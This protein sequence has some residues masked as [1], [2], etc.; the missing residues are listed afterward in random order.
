MKFQSFLF[1]LQ[2]VGL[3]TI[4]TSQAQQKL[5]Q[6][7]KN[8]V[9]DIV[10][11]MTLEEKARLVIG[12]GM[13]FGSGGPIIGEADGR[14]P[15]AAGNSINIDRFGI[16]GA[17][18]ADGPAGIRIEPYRNRDST[19][20]F[21]ATAWPVGTLL[22]SSWDTVLIRR[23]GAAF[24]NEVK[25][26]GTDVILAPGMNIQRDPLNGRNFEYFSEDPYLS[27]FMAASIV[28]GIQ[29]NGVGTSIKHF[30]AN[31]QETNRNTINAII[32]ERALR[33]I[34]LRGFEIAVKN[35]QPWTVMSSYNK[36]NGVYTSESNDLLTKILRGEWGFHGFVM[37]DWYGGRDKVAQ[38]MAGNDLIMP[39]SSTQLA[40]ILAAAQNGSL[41]IKVLDRNVEH[42]LNII[43]KMPT[44]LKYRYSNTPNLKAHALLAMN[45]AAESMVLLKNNQ[46]TLPLG[47][48]IKVALF[49]NTSFET[50][51][52]GT[53][54]GQVNVRYSVPIAEGLANAGYQVNKELW[55]KY[56]AHLQQDKLDHPQHQKLTLGTPHMAA[57]WNPADIVNKCAEDADVAIFSIGRNAGEGA[58]RVVKGNFNLS[59]IEEDIIKNIS[60]AFHA[61]GKKLIV[62]LNIGGVIETG[63][64]EKNADAILLTWQPGIEAGNAVADILGGAVNPSGK[65]ATTFPVKYEDCPSSKTFPGSPANKPTEA[66]YNEGIYVGYRYFHSFGVKPAFPFG[67]GLS[68]TK[69]NYSNLKVGSVKFDKKLSVSVNITNVGSKAGKEIVQLYLSAPQG[70]LDKPLEEL[71]GFSKTRL[72][73]PGETQTLTFTI[74]PKDLASFNTALSAWVAD[75]GKY[76][77]RIGA[78]SED[79]KLN[80]EFKLVKS[81]VVEKVQHVLVPQVSITELKMD[82]K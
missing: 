77:V 81:V 17:V 22:A 67:F 34:Y 79:I 16:P 18:Y 12:T 45:A 3:L 29:S 27:G 53:G 63:S 64:W 43:L 50:V 15:G 52:G 14:V 62:I 75:A 70:T 30:A 25:E 42:I 7:G 49:G 72:L 4:G 40:Q 68:Y 6:L 82:S 51:I 31:N 65:L 71:K 57:E 69:F 55:Q 5:P 13:R 60:E 9:K 26:Y 10:K 33:E 47:K 20:T 32:S 66:I 23:V 74:R 28:N 54:S 58:D 11:S 35:S 56:T 21:F 44:F 37:T 80:K 1:I 61:K 48:N 38:V 2:I 76:I 8:P 41:D 24:G 36:I 46:N 39:G 73:E 59:P 19:K 78:S